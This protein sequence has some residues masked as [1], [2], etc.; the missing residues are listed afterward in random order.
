MNGVRKRGALERAKD[1]VVK[2]SVHIGLYM[3]GVGSVAGGASGFV[4]GLADYLY[5][6]GP[7]MIGD[8]LGG[9]WHD[10]VY[11]AAE[12]AGGAAAAGAYAAAAGAFAGYAGGSL[13]TGRLLGSFSSFFGRV[14]RPQKK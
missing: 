1:Y 8:V 2:P 12:A 9:S 3:A 7:A 11:H 4:G 13:I 14:F 10:V 6:N 5:V